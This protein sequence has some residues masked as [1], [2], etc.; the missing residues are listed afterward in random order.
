[1]QAVLLPVGADV[2]AVPV[3]WVRQVVAAPA[4]MPLVTAPSVVLGLFNL[5]GEIVPLL[6]AAA[7]LG[8]GD[9]GDVAFAVVLISPSGPIGLA[10]SGFPE[11]IALD[12][13]TAA[14]ELPGTA[15]TFQVDRRVVVLLDPAALLASERLGG[16]DARTGAPAAGI[17]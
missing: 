17:G 6:D 14:S 8:V 10:A 1:M 7:L 16:P 2:Y 9:M 4:V 3:E 12:S 15:G 11:R 13:P 5:R